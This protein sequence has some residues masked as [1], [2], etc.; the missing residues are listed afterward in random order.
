MT[1]K[2]QSKGRIL[3]TGSEG[4]IGSSLRKLLQ[5]KGFAVPGLDIAGQGEDQ[6]DVRDYDSVRNAI[7][8]CSGVVHLAAVSR[9]VYGEKYPELCRDV[10]LNGLDNILKAIASENYRPWLLFASSREVYG[11]AEKLPVKESWP[12][13]P[14]NTYGETKLLSEEKILHHI[15]TAGLHAGILRFS[16]VYGGV[17]D[18]EDRVIPAFIRAAQS[19]NPLRVDGENCTFDFTFLEDVLDGIVRF[20]ALLE[21]GETL[22]E[23]VHLVGGIATTLGEL[24]RTILKITDSNSSL[25]ITP[26]RTYDVGKFFGD[27]GLAREILEW[28]HTTPLETGLLRLARNM[29]GVQLRPGRL[30]VPTELMLKPEPICEV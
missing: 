2:T 4:L 14:I 30:S 6:G 16:N 29:Q 18:Y 20:I 1:G 7:S 8:G 15:Q 24:A 25:D 9:V 23:P 11:N 28:T 27:P 5:D 12:L 17:N 21:R 22:P 19:G 10:N 26:T 3:V 13:L